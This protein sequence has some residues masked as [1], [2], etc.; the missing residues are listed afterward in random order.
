MAIIIVCMVD[1]VSSWELQ[2]AE[3]AIKGNVDELLD[4]QHSVW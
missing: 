2:T 1:E 4:Y 3:Q